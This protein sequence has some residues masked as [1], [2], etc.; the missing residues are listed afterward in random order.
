MAFTDL[1]SIKRGHFALESGLHGDVWFD[2]EP[3]FIRPRLLEPFLEGLGKSLSKQDLSGV[4]GALTGGAFIAF[5]IAAR[6]GLDF[7]YTE[8]RVRSSTDGEP[9]IDYALPDPLRPLVADR[10][11]AVVDDVIN[12]GS[13]VTKTF[14]E[15]RRHGANPVVFASILTVGG[16]APKRLAGGYPEVIC[17]EHLESNLWDPETCPLCRSGVRL[18]DPYDCGPVP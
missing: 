6:L 5:E 8:R 13:A 18:T 11:I 7:F 15:L 17:L 1:L 4:C 10:R 3:V 9:T 14:Q 12:A 2:L 16:P